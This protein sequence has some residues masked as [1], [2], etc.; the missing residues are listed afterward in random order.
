MLVLRTLK[1][2]DHKPGFCHAIDPSLRQR[3]N[4][5]DSNRIWIDCSVDYSRHNHG[6]LKHRHAAKHQIHLNCHNAVIVGWAICPGPSD[7][8]LRSARTAN[9]SD[10]ALGYVQPL[11][12]HQ[13][14]EGDPR[15][16]ERG[17]VGLGQ[18]L[19]STG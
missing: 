3:R 19:N 14:P 6:P 13:G 7:E 1:T 4:W 9:Q 16:G 5:R 8:G 2:N 18:W 17:K 12:P 15:T 10:I 11:Q